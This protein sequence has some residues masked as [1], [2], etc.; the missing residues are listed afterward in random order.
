[1]EGAIAASF[2]I[3]ARSGKLRAICMGRGDLRQAG[4]RSRRRLRDDFRTLSM[5]EKPRRTTIRPSL[6]T[7]IAADRSWRNTRP[8]IVAQAAAG[9]S[10]SLTKI[11][12]THANCT[13]LT[14]PRRNFKRSRDRAFHYKPWR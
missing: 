5:L 1:M 10:A 14:A 4:G 8:E 12:A 3:T 11:S 13:Q 7:D 9:S 6:R 2:E